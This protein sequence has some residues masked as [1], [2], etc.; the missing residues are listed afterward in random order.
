MAAA[1]RSST[2]SCGPL[3]VDVERDLGSSFFHSLQFGARLTDRSKDYQQR[4]QFG[5]IDPGP[6]HADSRRPAQPADLLRRQ[7]QRDSGRRLD[8]HHRRGRAVV[9]A[10]QPDH[11]LLRF[12][13]ELGGR[14]EHLCRLRPGQYR[15]AVWA[16]CPCSA[17][18]ASASSAPK[19]LSEST[20]IDQTLQ[21]DGS[22]TN[23]ADPGRDRER[24]HRLAAQRQFQPAA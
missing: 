4:T 3:S 2:T 18:S 11:L 12:A 13:F 23:V 24:V 21:P 14:R 9:R 5:F 8:R 19:T 22:V 16:T 6:A 10:D 17:M 7:L 15:G 1:R 20:R